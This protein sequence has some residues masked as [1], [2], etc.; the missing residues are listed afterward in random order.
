[1]RLGALEAGGTKMVCALGNEQGQIIERCTIPTTTPEETMKHIVRFFQD[2]QLDAIGIGCFGPIDL[3]RKSKTYG[4]ITST[5]KLGWRNFNIVGALANL[6]IPIGFDTDV[7]AAVLGETIYGASKGLDSSIYITVGTG[8]GVG[9]MVEGQLLHGLLHPEG[10]HILVRKH[11]KDDFKGSCPYHGMCL[12][13]M[14]S[15][16][17]IEKRWN[18]IANQLAEQDEVWNLEAYYLAQAI[19]NYMMM[20]SPK[21]VVLGGG[22]MKQRQLFPLIREQVTSILNGYLQHETLLDMDQY[23]VASQCEDNQGILGC[24]ELA[25]QAL[26]AKTK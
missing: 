3:N 11:P 4:Y 26:L 13:G 15:G 21:R 6:N 17:A 12:E 24:F 20:L 18:K 19:V 9:V 5:P 7:N 23:I 8:I 1:M 16:P 10:G 14:A 25:K 2:K 22:V